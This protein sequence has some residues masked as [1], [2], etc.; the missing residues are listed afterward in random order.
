MSLITQLRQALGPTAKNATDED[1]LSLYAEATGQSPSQVA[2]A[3]RYDLGSGSLSG[4]RIAGGIDRY[5]AG[6]YGLGEA[7]AGA[8][9]ATG[10]EDWFA[11]NR[12][13]NEFQAAVAADR[14]RG[15]GGIDSYKDVSGVSSALNYAGGLLANTAPY[16]AEAAVGGLAARGLM[17]GTR[18]ALNAAQVSGD[19]AAAA[20]TQ[21]ALNVGSGAGVFGATYPSA[22]GDI[23]QSQREAG[24]G[25]TNLPSALVG[26]VP[27]AAANLVG[28][29]GA[30]GRMGGFRSVGRALD[31][32]SGVRGAVLRAGATGARVGATEGLTETGQEGINQY[33]GRMAV[34]PEETL[35]SPEAMGRYAESFVGGA[36]LGGLGGAGLGGWR[37]SEQWQQ[38]Q[39]L[40][41]QEQLRAKREAEART[42]QPFDLLQQQGAADQFADNE[43][44]L[45]AINPYDLGGYVSTFQ[46]GGDTD[47][48]N[49]QV[50]LFGG[51]G[52]VA[53]TFGQQAEPVAAPSTP[54]PA[55]KVARTTVAEAAK[56]VGVRSATARQ[57]L[58]ELDNLELQGL[59]TAEQ[60]Q[61]QENAIAQATN[62]GKVYEEVRA[63][64][65]RATQPAAPAPTV[66]PAAPPRPSAVVAPP[67]MAAP[68]V[69]D[70]TQPEG[71]A[72]QTEDAANVGVSDVPRPGT[73]AGSPAG[74]AVTQGGVDAAGRVPDAAVGVPAP[75]GGV[76]T[77]PTAPA[78]AAVAQPGANDAVAEGE[79]A[80]TTG[81]LLKRVKARV[82]ARKVV[83]GNAIDFEA[84]DAALEGESPKLQL[85]LR[86]T[87]GVDSQG[88]RLDAPL[89]AEAAAAKAGLG[90]ASGATIRRL[91]TAL[92]LSKKVRDAFVASNAQANERADLEE[93]A[94]AP[95]SFAEEAAQE[96]TSTIVAEPE[97]AAG[98]PEAEGTE[99]KKAKRA[100]GTDSGK[101]LIKLIN[102]KEYAAILKEGGFAAASPETL[103]SFGVRATKH[104]GAYAEGKLDKENARL[105]Q[106][107]MGEIAKRE[108]SDPAFRRA[109]TA[110]SRKAQRD[111]TVVDEGAEQ[112]TDTDEDDGVQFSSRQTAPRGPVHTAESLTE[113]LQKFM[114]T[115]A[116]GDRVVVVG[117][118]SDLTQ[119]L[120]EEQIAD[121]ISKELAGQ[122]PIAFATDGK[123][124]FIADRTPVGR[125]RGL[126]M[127]EA[128]GHVGLERMLTRDQFTTLAKRI[129]EWGRRDDN[130]IESQVAKRARARVEAAQTEVRQAKAELVAYFIEEAVNAGIDPSAVKA[131]TEFGRWLQTLWRAFQNAL[132]KLD[133][134]P[135]TLT[136]QDIVD[137][138]YGAAFANVYE[139]GQGPTGAGGPIQFGNTQFSTQTP[140]QFSLQSDVAVRGNIDRLPPTLRGPTRTI[141][142]YLRK[143]SRKAVNIA[144][145]TTDLLDRAVRLGLKSAEAYKNLYNEKAAFVG[146]YRQQLAAYIARF[147]ELPEK[148]KGRDGPVNKL[149]YDST[150]EGKWAFQPDW[151]DAPVEVDEEMAARFN[152]LTDD[153]KAF[154][155]DSFRFGYQTLETK[156]QIIRE[157]TASEY[158]ALIKQARRDGDK[159]AEAQYKKD[160]DAA[161]RQFGSIMR[162]SGR[163]PYMPIK[164][165]GSYVVIAKSDEYR[166]AEREA[167]ETGDDTALKKLQ[168]DERHYYVDFAET[169]GDA[170]VV[171]EKLK[172]TTD[173]QGRPLYSTETDRGVFYREREL[174]RNELYGGSS[175]IQA[176]SKLRANIDQMY[177]KREAEAADAADAASVKQMRTSAKKLQDMVTELYILTLAEDSAR[178]SELRRKGVAGDI[179]MIRSFETQGNADAEFLGGAKYS[180]P[181]LME[182]NNMRRELRGSGG[183]TQLEKSEV[184]N[185]ILARHIQG[186][187]YNPS[188]VIDKIARLTSL[189]MLAM[190]PA[191]YIQ[192][193]TQPWLMSLPYMLGRHK[194]IGATGKALTDAYASIAP[195]FT[196]EKVWNNV[197]FE[198]LLSP[199]N[200]NLTADEKQMLRDLLNKQQLDI[201]M[202]T[203]LGRFSIEGRGK[204][205]EGARRIDESLSHFMQKAE[206]LNRI[207]TAL[208]AYRLEIA[209][210]S[211]HAEASAYA[212]EV[213][214][215][216][217]GDYSAW[218][219]PRAFNTNLGKVALQFRKFQL[220]QISLLAK[221]WKN[222]FG[223]APRA[224]KEAA[225]RALMYTLGSA[226]V[227]GG[228]RAMPIPAAV[229]WILS[230]A[231]SEADEPPE[232]MLRQ[233]IGDNAI[234]DVL[235][236]GIPAAFGVN[237]S[238]V[239][240]GNTFAVLPFTD[241]NLTN[242]QGVAQTTYAL[243]GG[244]VGGLGYKVSDGAAKMLNGEYWQGVESL[245]PR[246]FGAAM[247][248]IRM[249][250]E[251][252]TQADGDVTMRPDDYNLGQLALQLV[253]LT[254]EVEVR[255][256]FNQRTAFAVQESLRSQEQNIK[257]A[258]RDA[259]K[260]R[261]QEAITAAR[262]DWRDYNDRRVKLGFAA[263]PMKTLLEAPKEQGKRE[264][265][266]LGGVQY[267][268][269][270]EQFVRNLTGTQ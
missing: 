168:R 17:S 61:E 18:Q 31:D 48:T 103:A 217:H 202:A 207:S 13:A 72:L 260:A 26:A 195:A 78:P 198:A 29:E 163:T 6:W 128:G 200:G 172:A 216:T 248:A 118:A 146:T 109:F 255:R 152:A 98:E 155:V 267:R 113:A 115:R 261:D 64:M 83:L 209:K 80:K 264:S 92:G 49:P 15:L 35:F 224:E 32:A 145:F 189:W 47:V 158:D 123:A 176:L 56:R 66:A 68:M 227:F 71:L 167:E 235:V 135:D 170:E 193:A 51:G 148:M 77:P 205:R 218:N 37:R 101:G 144:A 133:V 257:K 208:A 55:P 16:L 142:N 21:R 129:A 22:V 177:G 119:Y 39:A 244:P 43:A 136:A 252:V 190:S 9:G 210:G 58:D 228:M 14:A 74:G 1:L 99:N 187:D 149:L 230:K 27:Y 156:K 25:Q 254:P 236:G 249:G 87:L 191:Y 239:G 102:T 166:A 150:R 104:V 105:L 258:Y 121:L 62:K 157:T 245:M 127:H 2:D 69:P 214:Y 11:R 8:L 60:V 175:T 10:A 131:D 185:E 206:A 222:S 76:R 107:A 225:R 161:M 169:M 52:E 223:D 259:I 250:T 140:M 28:L 130:S 220:I 126:F 85:A 203:E 120:S 138:A 151:L 82:E 57:I 153:A 3:A 237:T 96:A 251:G 154:V 81:P 30:L 63:F 243:F 5:Q 215:N 139:Y 197:N 184:F 182:L 165:F 262:Q 180:T 97:Q 141:T 84:M 36:T 88:D 221:L 134:A 159:K 42:T 33:F 7:A 12:R 265:A 266:T 201:G 137:F 226:F 162:L 246:G 45:Q 242:R 93:T 94:E 231:F 19:V 110:A 238:M 147:S 20:R 234:A 240:L 268:R 117:T 53:S 256:M 186:S 212:S 95:A 59:I 54:T 100:I 196:K 263:K 4:E 213:I 106:A 174:L 179:D 114:R 269:E 46:Q 219:A 24:D 111:A 79:E 125:E 70:F 247:K 192:N 164:R 67:G 65:R 233:A 91:H 270:N 44:Q 23:L 253:G 40:L 199:E 181:M 41:Q 73:G 204:L 86:W 122:R 183:A 241:I 173:E 178:R 116:L 132:R 143:Y 232:Y 90:K 50:G 112:E 89:S 188:P 124:Y 194:D 171:M 34:N 75:A 108:K 229:G 160:R 211:K 38:Q